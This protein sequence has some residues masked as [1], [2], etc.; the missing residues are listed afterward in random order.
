[1][2]NNIKFFI[3]LILLLTTT[4]ESFLFSG[5]IKSVDKFS[6]TLKEISKSLPT[7][8]NHG[9]NRISLLIP[10]LSD[11]FESREIDTVAL[12]D[13]IISVIESTEKLMDGSINS[14]GKERMAVFEESKKLILILK[15]SLV[16]SQ[17]QTIDYMEERFN[18]GID[19]ALKESEKWQNLTDSFLNEVGQDIHWFLEGLNII[20]KIIFYCCFYH[21]GICLIKNVTI[22]IKIKKNINQNIIYFVFNFS[23]IFF[24]TLITI[25]H[26]KDIIVLL[27]IALSPL[28]SIFVFGSSIIPTIR[29]HILSKLSNS[30]ISNIRDNNEI[31]IPE[32]AANISKEPPPLYVYSEIGDCS[33]HKSTRYY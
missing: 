15:E 4:S 1:M 30:I 25:I 31:I 22:S 20:R 11:A 9:F 5:K 23:V 28:L 32:P 29:P 26:R 2:K 16:E 24:I 33:S 3:F 27:S 8:I 14:I 13:K 6:D 17:F 10:E 7:N 12:K 18:K 21:S 19:K